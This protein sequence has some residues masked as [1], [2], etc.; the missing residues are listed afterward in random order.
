MQK[1]GC[2]YLQISQI[3]LKRMGLEQGLV[4]RKKDGNKGI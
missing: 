3:H 2:S 1:Q 4:E